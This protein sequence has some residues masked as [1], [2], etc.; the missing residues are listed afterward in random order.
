MKASI[1]SKIFTLILILLI[2]F[3][4]ADSFPCMVNTS[5]LDFEGNPKLV[6]LN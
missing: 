6:A 2:Q 1:F 3:C 5:I 4:S